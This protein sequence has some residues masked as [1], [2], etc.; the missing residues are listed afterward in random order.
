MKVGGVTLQERHARALKLAGGNGD[1]FLDPGWL[2]DPRIVAALVKSGGEVRVNGARIAGRG[3]DATPLDLAKIETYNV[4]MRAHVPLVLRPIATEEDAARATRDLVKLTQKK[5]LDLPAEYIDPPFEDALTLAL[6]KTPVT[7]NMVSYTCYAIAI[8]IAALFWQG[9]LV[10]GAALTYLVEWLDGVDG[11]LARLKLQFSKLGAFDPVFDYFYENLWYAAIMVNLRAWEAGATLI[12]CDTIWN[13]Q[14]ALAFRWFGRSL[15]DL[16][17]F[18]RAFRK[19]G[20]R[21]NIY[22]AMMLAGFIAG[23]PRETLWAVAAWSAATMTVYAAAMV[24]Y[25]PKVR[26]YARLARNFFENNRYHLFLMGNTRHAETAA[27]LKRGDAVTARTSWPVKL[28]LRLLYAC[29]L[30]CKMCGQWGDTGSYHD[31]GAEKKRRVLDAAVIERVVDDLQPRG[32]KYVDIEGGETFL[33]PK[34]IDLL[35]MLK[36]KGLFVKPV[37]NGT[38]MA[39]IAEDIVATRIDALHVSI[40]GDRESNNRVRGTSWAYDR[41]MEGLRA[42]AAARRRRGTSVP[43]LQIS[44]TMTRHNGP[45]AL[46]RLCADL[47]GRGLIDVLCVKASPIWI[48]EA[49]GRGYEWMVA[50]YFG[51]SKG[52][53]SWRGFLENY[54][55]LKGRAVEITAAIR[56][57]RRGGLDFYLDSVP[58]V[59][60]EDLTTM[61]ADYGFKLGRTH[62]PIAY[63]EPTIDADGNVYPCNLFTDEPMAM[64]NVNQQSILDIWTGERY[65]TFRRMLAERGGLLPIC[66]RCCQLTEY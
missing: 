1:V 66:N 19:I 52:V 8:G 47:K 65:E 16:G 6:S 35:R 9:Y 3:A 24:F 60:D 50:R 27:R 42:V 57:L 14:H 15:D 61:Y 44:F 36:G 62:C 64:G 31:F 11:K 37:T 43:L 58:H 21:R 32:L 40:D 13:V 18:M 51:S 48:P 63:L 33:Y 28:D 17:P 20:G 25:S 54:S 46:R 2:V 30:R 34:I 5:V 7:P 56:E 26:L 59:S 22:C 23:R 45:E 53:T 29:N 12:V 39:D 49:M 55:D 4:E 10:T 41:A 38:A